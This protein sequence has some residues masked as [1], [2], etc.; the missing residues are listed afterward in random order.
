MGNILSHPTHQGE[1]NMTDGRNS[2]FV[3]ATM[4]SP[5][6]LKTQKNCVVNIE[7]KKKCKQQFNKKD[8]ILKFKSTACCQQSY[9]LKT[10]QL[11]LIENAT[12]VCG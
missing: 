1:E 8:N 5:V 3:F 10:D 9:F 6:I 12:Y 7:I 2:C 11:Y 4:I